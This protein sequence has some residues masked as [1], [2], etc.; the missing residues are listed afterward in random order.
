M[1]KIL[2]STLL[3]ALPTSTFF[4]FEPAT[5]GHWVAWTQGT[6]TCG[7]NQVCAEWL[8]PNSSLNGTV[9]CI[10]QFDMQSNSFSACIV[11]VSVGP[12][13]ENL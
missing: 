10:D 4:A 6:E 3:I 7:Q 12:R 11:Q 2:L 13:E 1:K 8:Q 9:C 5:E